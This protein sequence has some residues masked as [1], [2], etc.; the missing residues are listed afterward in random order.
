MHANRRVKRLFLS[1]KK[2]VAIIIAILILNL[3]SEVNKP[4]QLV[5]Q[6][7][8]ATTKPNTGYLESFMVFVILRSIFALTH[9][10]S[11]AC[12][13]SI[14]HMVVGSVLKIGPQFNPLT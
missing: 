7:L 4:L 2:I 11:H 13:C 9:A 6:C 5:R 3:G 14:S 1:N 10:H 12:M 8:L